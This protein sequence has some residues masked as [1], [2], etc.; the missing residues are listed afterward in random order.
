MS[1][2]ISLIDM[3]M[4]IG[5][6]H[7]VLLTS[8]VSMILLA[9]LNLTKPSKSAM[10]YRSVMALPSTFNSLRFVRQANSAHQSLLHGVIEGEHTENGIELIIGDIQDLDTAK[11]RN[12]SQAR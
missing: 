12:A 8:S 4:G 10:P 3:E 1:F 2:I 11:M 9:T 7:L 6:Y 5:A